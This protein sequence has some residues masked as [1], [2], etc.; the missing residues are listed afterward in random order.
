[1]VLRGLNLLT[2]D[3]A[4]TSLHVQGAEVHAEGCDF[5]GLQG[6]FVSWGSGTP[7]I[8]VGPSTRLVLKDCTV[9]GGNALPGFDIIGQ[10]PTFPAMAI[11]VFGD[12]SS[13][14]LEIHGGTVQGGSG[15]SDDGHLISQQTTGTA[16]GAGIH[17]PNGGSFF[18]AGATISGGPGGNGDGVT[19]AAGGPGVLLGQ[20]A[21][22]RR[23]DA[24]ITGGA[25][26]TDGLGGPSGAPG[27][28]IQQVG[29]LTT[30]VEF[31]G[32]YRSFRSTAVTPEG[33]TLQYDYSGVQGDLLG[34]FLSPAS[35]ATLLPGKQGIFHLGAPLVGPVLL[36]PVSS[37]D[38]SLSL[39]FS[40][41][42]LGFGPE[43]A[44]LVHQQ[45]FVQ[46][47]ADPLL[48]SSPTTAVFVDDSL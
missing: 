24:A 14:S 10:D 36:G 2:G 41:P 5:A 39:S 42:N 17:A 38:G 15:G 40:V 19:G 25:G 22:L 35:G 45:A 8:H 13:V 46:P 11:N 29:A 1:V 12:A 47:I 43:D 30:V 9:K 4:G 32:A 3:F 26:G 18:I 21:V 20:Q 37:P 27:Q 33:D 7:A 44:L 23:L 16:G 31:P 28:A 48:L 6:D 34:L